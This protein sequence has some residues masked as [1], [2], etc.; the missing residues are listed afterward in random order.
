MTTI[1]KKKRKETPGFTLVETIITV[2]VLSVAAIG[3]TKLLI[4]TQYAAEDN[5]YDSTAL[6]VALS[7]LE[8]MKNTSV[9]LLETS[10]ENGE[11]DLVIKELD[12]VTDEETEVETLDLG[13]QNVLQIPLV[14]NNANNKTL[15]LTLTP[16]IIPNLIPGTIDEIVESYMLEVEYAFD[17]PQTQLNRTKTVRCLRSNTPVN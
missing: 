2:F 17:H 6:T 9:A 16:R 5:L 15:R 14:T 12:I 13:E 4:A 3:F 10:E 8:Q 11:F 1:F 7:T